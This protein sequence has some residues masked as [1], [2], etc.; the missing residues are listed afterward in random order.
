MIMDDFTVD[1]IRERRIQ[2]SSLF[3]S[4]LYNDEWLFAAGTIGELSTWN[5]QSV[6]VWDKMSSP[7]IMQDSGS[8]ETITPH[9]PAFSAHSSTIYSMCIAGHVL[10]TYSWKKK[11]R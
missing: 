2:N 5:M 7:L 1:I 10:I 9:I 4:A 11:R 8:L 6:M 3:A